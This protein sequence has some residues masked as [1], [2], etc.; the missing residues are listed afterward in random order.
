MA[1]PRPVRPRKKDAKQYERELRK[2]FYDPMFARLRGKLA[3]AAASTDAYY[4]LRQNLS[5][6]VARPRSGVPLEVVQSNITRM[7]NY[8]KYRLWRSFRAALGVDIRPL[9]TDAAVR[10]FLNQRIAENVDLIKTIPPRMHES[11]ADR[12]QAE[13][14]ERPFDRQRMTAMVRDEYQSSGYNLRRIVRDQGSKLNGQLNRM[15]QQQVGVQGFIWISAGDARVRPEHQDFD[16]NSYWWSDPPGEIPGEAIQ[17]RCVARAI[18][19]A[20]LAARLPKAA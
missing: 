14:A 20:A 11:L 17:C 12:M 13:F 8:N 1:N 9:L 16:G 4:A 3:T 6:I 19:T 2:T 15:R 10:S 18:V 5:E 7:S